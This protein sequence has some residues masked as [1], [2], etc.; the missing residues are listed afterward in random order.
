MYFII[1]SVSWEAISFSEGELLPE[2]SQLIFIFLWHP[3]RKESRTLPPAL[4]QHCTVQDSFTVLSQVHGL[5]LFS[6]TASL[7]LHHP[8]FLHLFNHQKLSKENETDS[9][10]QFCMYFSS[11]DKQ[12]KR[13]PKKRE[14]HSPHQRGFGRGQQCGFSSADPP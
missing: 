7:T 11:P 14:A 3:S 10:C 1:A 13:S 4:L 2:V 5:F 12:G 8:P 9:L 6:T